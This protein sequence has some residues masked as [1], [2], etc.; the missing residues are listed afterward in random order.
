[1]HA[2]CYASGH[3]AF[4]PEVPPEALPIAE[5]PRTALMGF[6]SGVARHSRTNDDLFV[7]GIPECEYDQDAALD[8]LLVF[9][10]WISKGAPEGVTTIHSKHKPRRN[11]KALQKM[12]L[13]KVR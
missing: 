5:G 12:F 9:T 10:K 3:I 13:D 2:F 4:G 6:I 7:P 11:A 8:A 1:M